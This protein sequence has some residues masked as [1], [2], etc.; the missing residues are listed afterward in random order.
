M[1]LWVG[2]PSTSSALVVPLPMSLIAPFS[3]SRSDTTLAGSGPSG[4]TT[5]FA[6]SL[7]Y[8]VTPVILHGVM[9]GSEWQSRFGIASNARQRFQAANVTPFSGSESDTPLAGSKPG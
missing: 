4:D 9:S 6:K 2:V 5:S 3:D 1:G 8:E 7:G